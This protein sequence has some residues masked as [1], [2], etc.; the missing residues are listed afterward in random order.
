MNNF[1]EGVPPEFSWL[2]DLN[3]RQ[4]EAVTAGDGPVLVIAGA[5]TGKTKTLAYRVA[6]LVCRGF[7]PGRI[8][9]LTFTR[10]A[11]EEM[12]RRANVIVRIAQPETSAQ[13]SRI[14]GGTFHAVANRL[15]RVYSKTIGLEESFTVLDQADAEDLM[16]VIRH[17]RGLSEKDKRFPRKATCLAIY[18]RSVNSSDP[19]DHILKT[20]FPWCQDW[21]EELK[22]LFRGYVD[23]KHA[24]NVLDYDDLLLFWYHLL[25]D[26]DMAKRIDA[27]FD[28]I[29][30]D[31]YQDTNRLQ[32]GILKRM[33]R[34]NKNIMVV[35]DDAQ[36]IYSF[37]A[38]DV[39][40]I[41][42]FPKQFPGTKQIT[43]EQN[44][45]SRQPILDA[46]N[47][48]IS[49]ARK[50][51]SKDLWSTRGGQQKPLLVTCE[52]EED[53]TDYVV[54]R[55]LEHYEQGIPLRRQA[56]LFRVGYWSDH[57]EVELSRR[58]IPFHK[59]GGLKFLEAAHVKDLLSYLRI[60]EN[61]R[62][63]LAWSRVLNLID[64]IGP[65]LAARGFAFVKDHGFDPRVI[66]QFTVP[67]A[68]EESIRRLG[69]L[70]NELA[71]GGE[72][73]VPLGG[74]IE[75]IRL[76]YEPILM[77]VYENPEPRLGDLD[78][79]EHIAGR[80]R[81]RSKFLTDLTL[82][83]PT[84]TADFA[85]V[86][87]LDDDWLTLSTIHS[88]K[89]CEWDVVYLIHAT[90]GILPSD[91]AT[92]DAEQIEEERRL[93]YV[94]CTRAK[95]WLYVLFPLRYY[96]R[97]H[98][99]GDGHGYAQLTRFIPK[100]IAQFFDQGAVAGRDEEEIA[101]KP[102]HLKDIRK[103]IRSMWE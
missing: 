98:Q 90:D 44:Y 15:L 79:M 10:R 3:Q 82:D 49:L 80:Y 93:L 36:S 77:K 101:E 97:K 62:D 9:L 1:A 47:R 43:L 40:N 73:R 12:I 91:L 45:R 56:V 59:Y 42:D 86:P 103:S 65:A 29:L 96:H 83:P 7:D 72:S 55:I 31:E 85:G 39:R 24:R 37:R 11:A 4:R 88:A 99:L 58:K 51:F 23:A 32:A 17:E 60:L 71:S 95:D 76:F 89:G 18:S 87:T 41:L 78:Q 33:R 52:R 67:K 61:P 20:Y 57:L 53:Q 35:G 14:W 66:G 64:G 70:F 25:G 6:R 94:A 22:G 75:Q 46:T 68:S 84:S 26:E 16:N 8:M 34:I 13:A 38:A 48:I 63:Q 50:R 30:V 27:S 100:Q 19:L 81:S 21:K 54:R 69:E 102:P 28:H 5:G 92:G 2:N 74:Q